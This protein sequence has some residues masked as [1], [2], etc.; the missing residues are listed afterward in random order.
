MIQ[1]YFRRF[2]KRKEDRTRGQGEENNTVALQAG[3]R[4]LHEIGPNLKRAISGNLDDLI[5]DEEDDQL[6]PFKSRS[7]NKSISGSQRHFD[8]S[9]KSNKDFVPL[10]RRNHSLFGNNKWTHGKFARAGG[11]KQSS[12]KVPLFNLNPIEQQPQMI[13]YQQMNMQDQNLLQQQAPLISQQI[14]SP[15]QSDVYLGTGQTDGQL[16]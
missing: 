11:K 5:F 7:K 1:D 14:Y 3:L 4:S 9:D 13:N 15:T 16:R 10:H 6:S 12:F 8:P 2:R